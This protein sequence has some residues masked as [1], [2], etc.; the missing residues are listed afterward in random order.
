SKSNLL[1]TTKFAKQSI[2]GNPPKIGK[3]HALSKPVT[4]NSIPTSQEAKV[5]KNDKVIALGMFRINPFK[6]SRE[7]K[8]V[9]NNP[10]SNTKNDRVPSA[11]KNSQS[12]NKEAEVEEHHRNLLLSKNNKHM[13]SACNNFKLDYQNVISKVVCA[14][15]KKC[16]ISVNHDV[17]L[18]NYVNG[19]TS[20]GKKQKANVSI[21]EKQQK[22]KPKVKKLKKVGSIERLATPKPSKPRFSLRWSPTG[23]LLDLKGKIIASSKSESQCDCSNGDNACTSNTLEP[24]IKRFPNST[25]LFGR[26]SRFLYGVSTRVVP[27]QFCDSDLEVAF[28]RNAC[29]IR[30]LEGVDLLK[31]DRSTNLYT[32]NLHDMASASAICLMARA[33]STKSWLW[34]QRKSKRASHPPKPVPN[35]RQR[36]HLLHMDLCG[37]MRIA[38]LNGKR[39]ILV[40]VDDYSHYTWVHFLRSKDEAPKVI[41][42]FLKRI[43]V[44]FHVGISHQVSSIRTP[45]QNRVVERKN[46]TLVEAARTMLIFS[47]VPLFLWAEAIATACFTQNCSIIHR[48]FNKTPYELINGKKPDISF[49]HVFGAMCYPKNDREDIG[50]LGAKVDIG[51]FIGYSADSYAYR[52]YNRRTKKIIETMNVSFDELLAMAFEQRSSK[53]RLQSMTSG[54]ISSGLDLTYAPSTITTQQPSEGELDLLFK[55]MYDDYIG[56]QPSATVRTVL[57]AHELQVRQTSTTSTLTADTAPTPT[58]LSSYATNIPITSQDVDELN[59]N[60]MID[61]NTFVNP[62]ANPSTSAAESSSSQNIDPSNMHTFY[63]PYPYEFQWTKDHPMEQ[64]VKEAM[65]DPTWIESMQEGILQFK[66]LDVWVLVPTPDNISPLTLKWLLKNKNDEE[67][68]VIRNKSCLVVRGYRQ[69]KVFQIDVKTA[70]LHGSLKEDVY[71]CQPE[72]FIDADNPS[73]VYKLKKALYG[74]KQAP[75]AWY[76]ELS[77]FLLQ[78]HFF[79]GTI[80]L[81]L[82]IRRFHDDILV[83]Q[84]C[85]DDIIFG[86]THPR[87]TQ[88]FSDLMKSRFEM[89]M[90]G[91]ITLFLGLQVNQSPCGIFINQS[92]YVLKILKK[93]GMESYDLVGTPMEIKDKLDLDQ[94]GTPVDATKYRSMIG[95]LMYLTSSRPDIV[96]ATCLCAWYQAKP[97]EKHLK[98]VKRIFRYLWGIVNTG[99]WYTKDYGFELIGFSDADYAGCKETFKSTFGGAQFIG[100]K[101]LTDYGFHFQKIPI[102]C[103]LKSAIGISCNPV[104]H[105]RTKHIAVRYHFIKEHMEK[106]TIELYFVKTDNQLADLFTKTLPADRFT[107][108]VRRLGM[109]KRILKKKTKT[110]PKTTKPNTEWKRSKKT[111][112]FEAKS[113]KSKPEPRWGFDSGKLLYYVPVSLIRFLFDLSEG[114]LDLVVVCVASPV[115]VEPL[116]IELP[117]LEDQ[118]REDPPPEVS[119]ADNRTMA[120]LHQAPTEG[121]EDAIV[122]PKIAANNFELKHG[123]INLVQNKQ[124]FG[125]DKEDPHAHICYFNKITSTMRFLPPSKMTNLRNEITRFQQR[126]DES[127]YEAWD[128]F[129]D[130][131][132]ACPHHGF[133][134][135]HQLDTLYN[136]LNVNDQD[137]LNSAAVVAKVSTSSSTPAISSDVAELKDMVRALLL[138]KKNQSSAPAPSLTPAP[139]KAVEP[140]YV[141]YGGSGTLSSNTITNPKEELKGIITRSGV[142]Y[143][144]PI[145]PTPAKVVK[146]G[147]EVTKDQ[148]QT[149]SSQSTA[150]VQPPIAQSKTQTLVFEPV[151]APIS[152]SMPNLK[153]SIP[154]PSR[155]DNERRRDQAN[156]QIEKFY[157]IFKDM[158]FEISFTDALILMPKF[159]STLKALIGNK[160]KLSEMAR[161]PMNKHCS[162]VILNKFPRKLGDAGKFLIPCEFPGMDE[163]LALADLGASINLM[164]LSVWEA[165]SLLKLT[166]TCMT[167]ELADRSVSK[168]I[169]FEPDPRV[170]LIL[171]RCFLKTGRALINVYKGELTLHIE[172]E[173][174]TYNLDQTSRYS[175]NYNQMTANKID[176]IDLAC[177]E[178]SHKVLGFSDVTTSENP[179]P[180]DD[181]IISTTSPTLTPFGDSDF[182][183]FEEADAFLSLEDDLNSSK[184]NP[185]YY[186]LE[187]D[188]LLLETILNSEPLPPLSNHEQYMPSFKKELKVCE[189]KTVKSSVDEPP[190]SMG[191]PGDCVPKKGG[192]TIV[193]NEENELIPTRL[194]TGWREKTTFTCT[195]GTF[196]YLRMPFGLCNAP[197]MFQRFFGNSFE[198]CLSRLNKMLQRAKVDVV[199]KLPYPTT[200][201]GVRSFFGHA[202]FYRRFIQDFSKISRPMTHL[203]E[204]NTPFIFFEDCIKALQMLKKKLTKAPILIAPNWDL[205]FELMCDASDFAIGAVLGQRH[206]KHFRPIHYA[207]KMMT[208]AES[209]YTTTEKEML[210]VVYAFEKFRSYLI[211]NKSIVHTDHSALKYLF[212]KKDAKARLLRWVLL[213]QEFDFN[214]LDMKGAGNLAADHLAPWFANFANYHAGNFIVKGMS[215]QQKNKF[216]KDVKHY[217]WDDPFLFKICTD[218]V[219]WRCVHGKEALDILEACHNGP[220]GGHHGANLTAKKVFDAGFFWLTI[221]KEAHEF[222]KNCDSCQRQGKISQRDEMPQN[223]IQI[224]EIFDVWGI[225]FMGPF[226][227]SQGNKYI[228]MAVD[229]LSKWIEAK[230]LP[231]NDARVVMLKYGVTHRLSIAFHPQTS[232]QVEV[233]NRGLKII[234]KRT[235]GENRA[236]WLDKLDD[237]LWA[238]RTAYKTPIGC[239]PYKLVYEKACHL[240]IE[241]EHKAYWALKQVNFDLAVAGDHRKVQLNELN[242]LHDHAYENSL[243]YKEK[244]KRIHDFKIKNR[245]FNVGDRVLLFN[246]ILKIFSSKLKTR[247]SRPFTIA[248]VFPYGTVELSQANMPNFKVNGHR[249]KHYFGGDVPQLDFPDC[250]VSRALSFSFTR[251]SHL[252]LHFGNPV[253][254]SYRLTFSFGIPNKWP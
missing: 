234:L 90:M 24:K 210:A 17:C 192:F 43:T 6:T 202:G 246:S 114:N 232:G 251:A 122:I 123:L 149:P 214:V 189:A 14:M 224:C 198:N 109:W 70:F 172:N 151:V 178:Y 100:E 159:T 174:I 155:R 49:L 103:D 226:P 31:G 250:E 62:F 51:F 63:Q 233:S 129:N 21:K 15:C 53:P 87:Y 219:I 134:E 179:T 59:P 35:S 94:N 104:Q 191:Q 112:S 160:E 173:A 180:Y 88:L 146:Q 8:L 39:Y 208:N 136:A 218:Q 86:S 158:S 98:E 40:I 41:K 4:S 188:I 106:G 142:A 44:L 243:I 74:L 139:V 200:L 152:A 20:R 169:D 84:V 183:I 3:I 166:P 121:Y 186:D 80:D 28:R 227:S 11:S 252:Q 201:K 67:Q 241:L 184:I 244:T 220:T 107:Y 190:E 138:D 222:V 102:Y 171:E 29:F 77:T 119:M 68:T 96:H 211:M 235:I 89:S 48:R 156:E 141:T 199:A 64:N 225:D 213:L 34:H 105:L 52:V 93:Y 5:V 113:Q 58:I 79:K 242:E 38:N 46:R 54:Q 99:L 230:A 76:D 124:F 50:K 126:F 81:T 182:L 216:F 194:V 110:K 237:A 2:L 239:T 140:N 116:R 23:R 207:S 161:T 204:K 193:K 209:N 205:P 85:V 223:S 185:F 125:H 236:S 240:P 231:T 55:A 32:I 91:E 165:L 175:A 18:D 25:S 163:C 66:R 177:E 92:K 65:T 176:V 144:G 132:R 22:Q 217:F 248:K 26:L 12:K 249:V 115:I 118:F 73:H 13:S 78:N 245:V 164:P 181:P 7:E 71:V 56:G 83:V 147:T 254:K 247:W 253:S 145:I 27:R 120:E 131:L 57:D 154:Y 203:L 33:S 187:G 111:K 228:L 82:F 153:P 9:P 10:R 72:G 36:L 61:G 148:V 101:L 47:R 69:E 143:Q 37:P 168:P 30:N 128:R 238:F 42:K 1:G 170:P 97:T 229:Y 75:R 19:K 206:E 16:L 221:Y 95:A 137:S 197:G 135:I 150:P 167:L 45:Q 212:A 157:E 60:A 130:L 117:F 195:Y 215:S 133:S 196:A 127:F 162:M 108:L